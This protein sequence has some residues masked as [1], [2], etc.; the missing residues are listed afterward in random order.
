MQVN[1]NE[2]FTS[3]IDLYIYSSPMF[4]KISLLVFPIHEK[5]RRGMVGSETP[6]KE[7]VR[8]WERIERKNDPKKKG[9]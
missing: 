6:L 1:T 9:D 3:W 7:K 8:L 5:W 4:T 2:S